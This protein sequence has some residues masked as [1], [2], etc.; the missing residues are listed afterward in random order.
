MAD[1]LPYLLTTKIWTH[2]MCWNRLV[3]VCA[4]SGFFL[5]ASMYRFC[6]KIQNSHKKLCFLFDFAEKTRKR[7]LFWNLT[8]W[9][10]QKMTTLTHFGISDQKK[11]ERGEK[12]YKNEF[13]ARFFFFNLPRST[14]GAFR[15]LFFGHDYT[16][17]IP[18]KSWVFD[19]GLDGS[20]LLAFLLRLLLASILAW[21]SF[22]KD[23]PKRVP[24][25]SPKLLED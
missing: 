14:R 17:S 21:K 2:R 11:R 13:L 20:S 19:S 3:F 25:D 4:C 22:P 24:K 16:F 5:E 7:I 15:T 6:T 18:S 8:F 23:G 9:A 1:S 10:S 12:I